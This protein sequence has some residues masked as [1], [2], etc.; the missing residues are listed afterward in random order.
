MGR[1]TCTDPQCLYKD[2]LY[3]YILFCGNGESQIWNY[4]YV[5]EPDPRTIQLVASRYGLEV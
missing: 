4:K 2:A 5:C 1:T 3:L